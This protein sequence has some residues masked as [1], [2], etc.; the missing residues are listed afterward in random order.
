MTQKSEKITFKG[1][2]GQE[3]AGRLDLPEGNPRGVALFAHC[4]TCSKDTLA[5][6]RISTTLAAQ[7]F[8]VLRFDFTGLGGSQGDFANT[9]FSSNVEDLV[10]AADYLRETGGAPAILVG[11]SFGG[12][13]VLAAARQ[14]P[15]AACVATV[16]APYD[17]AHVGHLF[18]DRLEDIDRDG[19]AEVSIGG[20]PFRV[21]KAFIED[22]RAQKMKDVIANLRRPLLVFHAPFDETVGIEN[23]G[24]IF[25][26]A[27]HPKSFVSLDTADH[28][29]SKR[30]D[31]AYVGDVIAAWAARYLG[32]AETGAPPL[33]DCGTGQVCVAETGKGRFAQ[34]INAGGHILS[35]DEPA[36]LGGTDTGPTPYD[37]LLASLGACTSMT[38]RMYAARKRWPLEQVRVRLSH[39][40]I[41]SD[42]CETCETT[43]ARIDRIERSVE[44]TGA[45]TAE[46]RER[47]LD[48]ADKCPVHR[49]LH[50]EV[51]IETSLAAAD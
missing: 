37:L 33:D 36:S 34:A 8:T 42:D 11:H 30:Q 24:E 12:P 51:L 47:L 13:A 19:H 18:K 32:E 3:L 14:I 1:A 21:K 25:A 41:H 35:A 44:I 48:I 28:L 49:T 27:K 43:N 46:Q 4:F 15:E 17:P 31:A 20:R 23:A 29:L 26:A 39:E 9:N 45:L 6:A 50:S 7:G 2:H 38:L 5:A 40:K 10:A 16:G 22:V